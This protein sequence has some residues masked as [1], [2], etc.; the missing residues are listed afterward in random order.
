[1]E[2]VGDN[3]NVVFAHYVTDTSYIKGVW[4]EIFDYLNF[5]INMF[6]P[7]ADYSIRTI[8]NFYEI[9]GDIQQ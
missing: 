5:F 4:Q 7:A 3:C 6:P 1:M 2:E 9:H 8:S